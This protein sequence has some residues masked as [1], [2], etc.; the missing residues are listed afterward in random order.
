MTTLIPFLLQPPAQGALP[1]LFAATSED[2]V[3]GGYYGPD[4]IGGTRGYPAVA[5]I[6]AQAL[7][8]QVALGLWDAASILTG[9]RFNYTLERTTRR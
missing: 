8:K 6:P 3:G 2:A 7:D 1:V 9:A 5:P 4:G